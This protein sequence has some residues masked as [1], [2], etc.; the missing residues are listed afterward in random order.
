VNGNI[1]CE[2]EK[3]REP[4]MPLVLL[5]EDDTNLL[6]ALEM[7][8]SGEGYRVQTA[9]DGVDAM[10]AVAQERPDLIVSDVMMPNMD[11]V[12]LV[13][14]LKG[15]PALADIPVVVMSAADLPPALPFHAFL[16]KPFSAARLLEVLRA[17]LPP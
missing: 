5:V 13:R 8:V 10:N 12:H 17:V 9:A 15:V 16:P 6:R 1:R 11:G 7:L 4:N 3:K 14:L 2:T